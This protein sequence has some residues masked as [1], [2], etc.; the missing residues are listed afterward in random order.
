[1][2]A[3]T[4]TSSVKIRCP[5]KLNNIRI[6]L[7][8][9]SFFLQNCYFSKRDHHFSKFFLRDYPKMFP[10][11]ECDKL[12]S[13]K[14][15]LND[16]KRK[17]HNCQENVSA[18]V[19]KCGHCEVFLT[20]SCKLLRHLRNQHEWGSSYRCFSCPTYFGELK[21]LTDH[22]EQYHNDISSSNANADF[23]DLLGFTTE[24]VN[25]KFRI[26]RLKFDDSGVLETFTYLILVREKIISFVNA[27]LREKLNLNLL[28][29]ERPQ[30]SRYLT[31]FKVRNFPSSH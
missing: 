8:V 6:F 12:L 15:A 19:F 29:N 4:W 21:A 3:K 10:C 25:S 24:G 1:M 22:Q 2:I 18:K 28:E 23:S 7:C 31:H 14:R 11:N 5:V 16:H 26:H 13:S 9:S 17:K 30:S 27:L 20:K